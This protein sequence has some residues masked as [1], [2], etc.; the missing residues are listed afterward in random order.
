VGK[1]GESS[2]KGK[3]ASR[4][5]A[6]GNCGRSGITNLL[7]RERGEVDLGI[8]TFRARKEKD[9]LTGK[10]TLNTCPPAN[11]GGEGGKESA[12]LQEKGPVLAKASAQGAKLKKPWGAYDHL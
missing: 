10:T 5:T 8:S 2:G 4:S 7:L 12:W 11:L 9:L 3:K 6:E 1:V